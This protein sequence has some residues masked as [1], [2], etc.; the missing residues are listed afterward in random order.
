[1]PEFV[2]RLVDQIRDISE[3][4]VTRPESQTSAPILCSMTKKAQKSV[5]WRIHGY[6]GTTK[7]F[8]EVIP[9]GQITQSNL[10]EL[11][12][13]LA[14]RCLSSR[15]LVSA[16]A[17]RNTARFYDVLQIRKEIDALRQ[18]TNFNCGHNPHYAATLVV[19]D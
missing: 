4:P 7:I 19:V 13:S 5:C 11:L 8:D 17:K 12:R 10:E 9:V 6:D 14:G 3:L 15:E 2:L 1:M 18:R 16:Y